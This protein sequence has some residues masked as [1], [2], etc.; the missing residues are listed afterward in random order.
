MLEYGNHKSAEQNPAAQ[1]KAIEKD[2]ARGYSF[3][4]TIACAKQI[5]HGR[6]AP[7]GIASQLGIDE[8]GELIPK[9]RLTHDQTMSQGFCPSVNQ[10]I[11]QTELTPLVYGHCLPRM[12]HQVVALR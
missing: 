1:K 11:D 10:L 6:I 2:T 7:T 9:D 12:I 3:P 8:K 5:Q 4:L